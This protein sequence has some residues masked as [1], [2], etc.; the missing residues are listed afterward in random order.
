M[1][2]TMSTGATMASRVHRKVLRI[3]SKRH[4]GKALPGKL[5]SAARI[6]G[7]VLPGKRLRP[8]QSTTHCDN[9]NDSGLGIDQYAE[10]SYASIRP[11]PSTRWFFCQLYN[12]HCCIIVLD[13]H[14]MLNM[15]MRYDF[16]LVDFLE[17]DC[18]HYF[19]LHLHI[20][21]ILSFAL[22]HTSSMNVILET[23]MR[24][25]EHC[26]SVFE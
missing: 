13:V 17:R 10:S 19:P 6:P 24:I 22:I 20:F 4:P 3:P 26:T 21:I 15:L 12:I 5:L 8:Q 2:M 16:L 7:K 25:I 23:K 9:S 1:R 11:I 14:D 18:F